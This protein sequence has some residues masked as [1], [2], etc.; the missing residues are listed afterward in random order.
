MYHITLNLNPHKYTRSSSSKCMQ[1]RFKKHWNSPCVLARRRRRTKGPRA[2]KIVRTRANFLLLRHARGEK[3]S[4]RERAFA[5]I[6]P[7]PRARVSCPY[8]SS[9]AYS[10]VGRGRPMRKP[11][12]RA[13]LRA[14][15]RDFNALFSRSIIYTSLAL[16]LCSVARDVCARIYILHMRACYI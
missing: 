16:R 6:P 5:R 10:S 12:T 11:F 4:A 15:L 14:L 13:L 1:P 9:T 2:R 3:E 7:P 8:S